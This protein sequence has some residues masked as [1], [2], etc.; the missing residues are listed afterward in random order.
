LAVPRSD[1]SPSVLL[2]ENGSEV[3]AT[4]L[5]DHRKVV[6]KPLDEE[7]D[8]TV[9]RVGDVAWYLEGPETTTRPRPFYFRLAEVTDLSEFNRRK[10]AWDA[11]DTERATERTA[12][13]TRM[14]TGLRDWAKA[15]GD[16]KW[17]ESDV[18]NLEVKVEGEISPLDNDGFYRRHQLLNHFV[19]FA[20]REHMRSFFGDWLGKVVADADREWSADPDSGRVSYPLECALIHAAIAASLTGEFD[21]AVESLKHYAALIEDVFDP[22]TVGGG[23]MEFGYAVLAVNLLDACV[24]DERE[25][26]APAFEQLAQRGLDRCGNSS[27]DRP[28]GRFV[29]L[30]RE[31]EEAPQPR[32]ATDKWYHFEHN[33]TWGNLVLYFYV[34]TLVRHRFPDEAWFTLDAPLASYDITPVVPLAA[35][36]YL[37]DGKLTQAAKIIHSLC[38]RDSFTVSFLGSLGGSRWPRVSTCPYLIQAFA[39]H[40]ADSKLAEAVLLRKRLKTRLKALHDE[41]VGA[42]RDD[43]AQYKRAWE[44]EEHPSEANQLTRDIK[45]KQEHT[46]ALLTKIRHCVEMLT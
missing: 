14:L 22:Q 29:E 16:A 18:L 38:R 36:A 10:T 39:R 26:Y 43:V 6:S 23:P 31:I 3:L 11:T 17:G 33:I 41:Y 21:V 2:C 32:L 46:K 30:M 20:P 34:L 35:L 9:V 24:G 25:A 4:V 15:L 7:Q 37:Q 44:A 12:V 27:P 42:F 40:T 8:I 1:A 45:E 19:L 5:Y 13:Q 28:P